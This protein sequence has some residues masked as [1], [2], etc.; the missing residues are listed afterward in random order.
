MKACGLFA[1]A[2]FYVYV[3]MEW[4]RQ[5]EVAEMRR[6]HNIYD[7]IILVSVNI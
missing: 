3:S 1:D 4:G 7:L 5:A 6:K 2:M